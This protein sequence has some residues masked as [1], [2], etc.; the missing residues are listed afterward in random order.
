MAVRRVIEAVF[1]RFGVW[2]MGHDFEVHF[3][4]LPA[5]VSYVRPCEHVRTIEVLGPTRESILS[6]I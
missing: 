3:K 2:E 1:L 4:A 5:F 6:A